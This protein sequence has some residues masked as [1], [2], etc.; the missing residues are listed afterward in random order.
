MAR[1]IISYPYM[2]LRAA[3]AGG[4]LVTGL[5]QTFVFA[6]VLA[7]ERFSLFIFVA[8]LGW[9]LYLA[10]AGVVKVLFVNLR[11]RFLRNK[12]LGVVGGQAN[13]LFYV[14]AA[15]STSAAAVCFLVLLSHFHY[16]ATDS[17]ELALFFFFNS[18]N[19]PWFALRNISIAI[20]EFYSFEVLEALRR[21]LNAAALV[22]LLFGLM[23]VMAF[24]VLINAGWIAAAIAAVIRLRER[25]AFGGNVRR[26]FIALFA[27]LR[28]NRRHIL[29]STIQAVSDTYIYNFP[30]YLVPWAY[31]L[32]A[33]TIIF[34][35]A[36]KI[37]RGNQM[38]YGAT[39]DLFVPRQ[40][41]AFN[42]RDAPTLIRATLLALGVSAIPLVGV[43][44]VLFFVQDDFFRWLL[45]PA[46]V[47]PREILPVLAIMLSVNMVKLVAYSVL[48]HCGFFAEAA[49]LGPI[50]IVAMT[51]AACL[52][53]WLKLDIVG[54]MALN[55]AGY[56]VGTIFAFLAL[57]RGPIR[58]ASEP[59]AP[60]GA[61]HAAIGR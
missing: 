43:L 20:D 32:G 29:N 16:A 46:A 38:I 23:S 36:Y 22:A 6:R 61:S 59:Q 40:T 4:T 12:P 28:S 18:I 31:G 30:Y 53:I 8:A 26:N 54:F 5:L 39:T 25:E 2:I 24:L 49:R 7:P 34:D 44:G 41:R 51:G 50:F 19:L 9:T 35:T 27:F 11:G 13:A 3:T 33:P 42:D 52:A 14:Y 15:L 21:A 37:F 48:I 55:A 10:D 17:A 56:T 45:G 47:M 58:V 1:R 57:I 60:P